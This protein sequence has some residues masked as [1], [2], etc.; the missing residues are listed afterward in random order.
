MSS[1]FICAHFNWLPIS[2]FGSVMGLS[3]LS[4]AWSGAHTLWHVPELIHQVLALISVVV[5]VLLL[6]AYAVKIMTAWEEVKSEFLHP[7][8]G[9]LFGT[10]LISALLLPILIVHQTPMLA[11]IIWAVAILGMLF[12]ALHWVNRWLNGGFEYANVAPAWI[13][14]VVGLLDIPIAI[15]VLQLDSFVHELMLFSLAVGL[16]FAIPLLVIILFRILFVA[17][18]P[19][20]ILPSLFILLAPFAVGFSAYVNVVGHVDM[21][22]QSL[23]YIALFLLVALFIR[24][25]HLPKSCPFKVAW[26]SVSFPLAAT[27]N[28]A[29]KMASVQ[30]GVFNEM[31]ALILLLISSLIIG[32]L[33]LRTFK[34][35]FAGEL[36]HLST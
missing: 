8:A 19:V 22:A 23:F 1:R 11:K 4:I 36:K 35:V 18:L 30:H 20:V 14:P 24:L 16:F 32:F 10:P 31:L 6:L 2:L 15:N 3:G 25:R 28:A 29:L 12:L 26:W 33:F 27:T 7:T 34:G 21:L 5:F 13:V 17:P 9:A